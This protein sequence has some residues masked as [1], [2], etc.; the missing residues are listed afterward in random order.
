MQCVQR[1]KRTVIWIISSLRTF[2]SPPSKLLLGKGSVAPTGNVSHSHISSTTTRCKISPFSP[3]RYIHVKQGNTRSLET[4]KKKAYS[5]RKWCT[6][7]LLTVITVWTAWGKALDQIIFI[8]ARIGHRHSSRIVFFCCPAACIHC[9]QANETVWFTASV[10]PWHWKNELAW[11]LEWKPERNNK[12]NSRLKML[13]RFGQ[14]AVSQQVFCLE[15][16]TANTGRDLAACRS[17]SFTSNATHFGS[18][19][20][21]HLHLSFHTSDKCYSSMSNP[22]YDHVCWNHWSHFL[23]SVKCKLSCYYHQG[24]HWWQ[25]PP[26]LT[27]TNTGKKWRQ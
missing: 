22:L 5:V 13:R 14:T 25:L 15:L 12:I 24:R 9:P 8:I 20:R 17:S 18:T 11:H 7:S 2:T 27:D 1:W 19:L 23:P 10:F 4:C 26:Q 6:Y 3:D 21:P 16:A